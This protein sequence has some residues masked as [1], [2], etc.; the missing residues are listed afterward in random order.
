MQSTLQ[1]GGSK[2]LQRDRRWKFAS[3]PSACI[4]FSS[5]NNPH[6]PSRA[7][8]AGAWLGAPARAP[9]LQHLRRRPSPPIPHPR[10]P[11][12]SVHP[13]PRAIPPPLRACSGHRCSS[14]PRPHPPPPSPRH[15]ART[16]FFCA[17]LHFGTISVLI[18]ETRHMHAHVFTH[19]HTH[20]R[21][22][23]SLRFCKRRIKQLTVG[24]SLSS[25]LSCACI[26]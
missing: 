21:F 22:R 26:P 5:A 2:D 15:R 1:A 11:N 3:W 9:P 13:P 19:A 24:V 18:P 25:A 12:S 23:Q 6:T 8:L 17:R 14:N 4:L 7:F 16:P 10:D 20:T